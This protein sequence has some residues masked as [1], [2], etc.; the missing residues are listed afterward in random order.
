MNK[1]EILASIN[2]SQFKKRD[3]ILANESLL[4]SNNLKDK[5]SD[6]KYILF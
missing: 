4:K 1:N 2:L 5:E 3:T 6:G